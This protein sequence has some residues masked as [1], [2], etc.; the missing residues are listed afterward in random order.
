LGAAATVCK[1]LARQLV[2]VLRHLTWLLGNWAQPPLGR[3]DAC[4]RFAQHCIPLDVSARGP[5]RVQ[6]ANLVER[7]TFATLFKRVTQVAFLAADGCG[8]S[9]RGAGACDGGGVGH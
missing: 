3:S 8:D 7:K 9:R 4:I 5:G 2:P 1:A 6:G